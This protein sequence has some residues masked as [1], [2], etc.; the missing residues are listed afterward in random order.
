MS[1][2]DFVHYFSCQ[3]WHVD[4]PRVAIVAVNEARLL[5]R[6]WVLGR[7]HA[8]AGLVLRGP[9]VF[10]ALRYGLIELHVLLLRVVYLIEAIFLFLEGDVVLAAVLN[11]WLYFG[12]LRN[13]VVCDECWRNGKP[14]I[15][16]LAR[17]FLPINDGDRL[18]P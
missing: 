12:L 16:F 13:P 4:G 18:R 10:E 17:S 14:Q 7:H 9:H 11:H 3:W 6:H 5:P 1:P 8:H 15:V 2:L